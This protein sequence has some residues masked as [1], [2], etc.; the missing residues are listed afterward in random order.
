MIRLLVAFFASVIF[1]AVFTTSSQAEDKPQ[2]LSVEFRR[3][4][5]EPV[6]GWETSKLKANEKKIYL[7]PQ[8][9]IDATDIEKMSLKKNQQFD[10]LM[11]QIA[12]S[13]EGGKKMRILTESHLNKP[14]A[15]LANGEVIMAPVIRSQIAG[16]IEIS[17][18][19]EK[20][21]KSL[22]EQFE[23]FKKEPE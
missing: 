4:S 5:F 16:A 1:C 11:V 17:G 13:E 22:V 6:E 20:Q 10:E 15:I 7:H 21:A 9:E 18:L 2:E 19:S 8:A 23:Q 12:L 3:A 14:M